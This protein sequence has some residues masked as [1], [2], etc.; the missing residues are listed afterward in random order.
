MLQEISKIVGIPF[1]ETDANAM[2]ILK[3]IENKLPV[4]MTPADK[5][6][7][8]TVIRAGLD[9]ND[10]GNAVMSSLAAQLTAEPQERIYKIKRSPKGA[11]I[12]IAAADGVRYSF[13]P[14]WN[15]SVSK[16]KGIAFVETNRAK[17]NHQA[18]MVGIPD[19]EKME[20]RVLGTAIA[21]TF[22]S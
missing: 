16:G 1:R 11:R 19:P 12:K 7:N 2:Q 8:M 21:A 6:F 13:G 3:R 18:L 5:K 9:V 10:E 4:S 20:V 17:L 15:L 14:I 22:S